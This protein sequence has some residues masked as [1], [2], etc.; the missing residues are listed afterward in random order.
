MNGLLVLLIFSWIAFIDIFFCI[1]EISSVYNSYY[2]MFLCSC[3][4]VDVFAI[5]E[6]LVL[7]SKI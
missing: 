7:D 5:L 2:K 4:M 6:I 3:T 1:E